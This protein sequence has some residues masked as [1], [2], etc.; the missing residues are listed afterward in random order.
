MITFIIIITN[1]T[2]AETEKHKTSNRF[3]SFYMT[4]LLKA[5]ITT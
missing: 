1:S 3:I 2:T 5:S 4:G